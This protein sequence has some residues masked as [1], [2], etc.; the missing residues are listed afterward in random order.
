VS[1]LRGVRHQENW[2]SHAGARPATAII[3]S[4]AAVKGKIMAKN[5]LLRFRVYDL[6]SV[7]G[8][9]CRPYFEQ[10]K[11]LPLA[12]HV[13]PVMQWLYFHSL[14][15]SDCPQRPPVGSVAGVHCE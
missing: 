13:S 10:R 15:P 9:E 4:A 6:Q 8:G 7:A 11:S 5:V 14:V 3:V 1:G 2:D 12:L